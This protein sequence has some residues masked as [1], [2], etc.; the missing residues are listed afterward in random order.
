METSERRPEPSY[1]RLYFTQ[2]AVLLQKSFLLCLRNWKQ[3]LGQIFAPLLVV[4]LLLAIQGLSNFVLNKDAPEPALR[5]FNHLP[6]CWDRYTAVNGESEGKTCKTVIFCPPNVKWVEELM[7]TVA[8]DN[9]LDFD[10]DFQVMGSG[11]DPKAD[12]ATLYNYMLDNPNTTQTIIVFQSAY[13]SR[14]NI[15]PSPGYILFYNS[16]DPE[17]EQSSP[18]YAFMT[19]LDGA[20]FSK[21]AGRNVTMNVQTRAYPKAKTRISQYDIV[22]SDGGVW[23]YI[24]PMVIF[25]IL[26]TEV[27]TEKEQRLRLGMRMMGMRDSV[28]WLVWILQGLAF[29]TLSTLVLIFAGSAAQF[30]FFTNSD[31]FALFFMFMFFGMA[32]QSVG[33]FI[34]SLIT[35][36]KTAQTAGYAAILIGFVFQTILCGGYG[37]LIDILY[38]NSVRPWIRFVRYA[39]TIYPPFNFARM[40]SDV[41]K[42]AANEVNFVDGNIVSGPGFRWTDMF[43]SNERDMDYLGLGVVTIPAPVQGIYLLAMD[44]LIFLLLT[45]YFDNVLPGEHGSPRPFWFPFTPSYWGINT[46]RYQP[47]FVDEIVH[48]DEDEDVLNERTRTIDNSNDSNAVVRV[49]GLEK[50]Y[51]KHL[52]SSKSDMQA[53]GGVSFTVEKG[54]IFCLLGHNGAGKTT[55]INMLTGLFPPSKGTGYISGMDIRTDMD[56]IRREMGVTPQHDILWAELSALEHLRIF[57]KLKGFSGAEAEEEIQLR[58]TKMG[59]WEVRSHRVKTFSGG[60]KR[61]LS[62]AIAT[63]GGPKVIFMDE[64]STGMDPVNRRHMWEMIHNLKREA[65]IVLT[66][67]SM[68]E[69]QNLADRISIMAHGKMVCWKRFASEE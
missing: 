2:L 36:S 51:K 61:R 22:A 62:V 8:L 68:E 3:S 10:K 7:R 1:I 13:L 4:I 63:I 34:S 26:L 47:L 52:W 46:T 42:K 20:I 18:A 69:A 64:P 37:I 11:V 32:I 41:A 24:P 30:K 28:Y 48:E 25:F 40:Y 39:F 33:L 6:K 60:M 19:S 38:D 66:T 65:S 59:L 31:F 55:S 53:V 50:T 27:V 67:H 43:Q 57:A 58:L 45:W 14:F 35:R 17:R 49:V 15:P 16:T 9:G 12:N 54:E 23:F 29:Q 44:I 21:V 5:T 56:S